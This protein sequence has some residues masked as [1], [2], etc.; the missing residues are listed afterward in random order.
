MSS[1]L[2][3]TNLTC[4]LAEADPLSN[5]GKLGMLFG[6]LAAGVGSFFLAKLLAERLHRPEMRS[7][8]TIGMGLTSI[9]VVITSLTGQL[10]TLWYLWLVIGIAILAYVAAQWLPRMIT[11]RQTG[12]RVTFALVVASLAALVIV[13]KDD[14]YQGMATLVILL[15]AVC[16]PYLFAKRLGEYLRASEYVWK[17]TCVLTSI[18]VAVVIVYPKPEGYD[19][20]GWP[21]K[22][23][24][25]LQGGVNLIYQF[26]PQSQDSAPE[27]EGNSVKPL[28]NKEIQKNLVNQL[29]R[30]I[31]P[32]GANDI[33][34]RPYGEQQVEV[35]VPNVNDDEIDLI[36]ELIT[37]AGKLEFR[38]LA[39]S[40]KH[41][42][43]ARLI[44][45]ER[46]K[47]QD[48]VLDFEAPTKELKR[49]GQWV[50][51]AREEAV[52]EGAVRAFRYNPLGDIMRDIDT[53]EP[54]TLTGFD[55]GAT[56]PEKAL[57]QYLADRG[58][59]DIEVL[60]YIGREDPPV[61]GSDLGPT[62]AG[63]ENLNP[64]IN[65]TLKRGPATTKFATLTRRNKPNR[66]ESEFSKLG[67]ILDGE[68]LS[69]PRIQSQINGRG[70]I[71][72]KFTQEQVDRL[73]EILRA[74][75]LSA[76]LQDTPISE[77][78]MGAELGQ[79]TINKGKW[80][81]QVS[82]L[83]VIVFVAIYYRFAG[84]VACLALVLNLL[85]VLATMILIDAAFTLPGMAGLI[86]TVGMSVDANVLI[87]ERI[88]EELARGARLRMA[89]RNGFARATT[90]I[91]DANL[92]T[93]ITAIVLYAIGTDQIRGFAVT[94]IL[95]I[96]M[97]MY[98]AIFCSRIVFELA[99][100]FR[101]FNSLKMMRIVGNTS[102]DFVGKRRLAGVLS[103]V[104]ISAGLFAVYSRGRD[105]FDIDFLGGTA[106]TL[107]LKEKITADEMDRICEK[108]FKSRRIKDEKLIKGSQEGAQVHYTI[109]SLDLPGSPKDT[110]WKLVTSVP[111]AEDLQQLVVEELGEHLMAYSL[112][113]GQLRAV[114]GSEGSS[115]DNEAD[116]APP[117]AARLASPDGPFFV[118]IDQQDEA[119]KK[120]DGAAAADETSKE[121]SEEQPEPK[122]PATDSVAQP[123][124]APSPTAAETASTEEATATP[125]PAVETVVKLTFGPE[126]SEE[127]SE[128]V[129]GLTLENKIRDAAEALDQPVTLKEGAISLQPLDKGYD[130]KWKIESELRYREWEVTLAQ[131]KQVSEKILQQL[132]SDL[133]GTPIFHSA[134][135]IGSKVAGDSQSLAI[136]A[137]LTSLLGIVG[138]IWIRF[139]RVVYGLA[140]VVALVHD[141]LITLGAIA[142]SF[143]VARSLNFLQV[144]EFSIS[145][146]IVAAFLTIIGYSLNDTIV[147]FDRIRE[148]RGKSPDLTGAMINDSINQTLSRTIL[149]SLTTFIVVAILYWFGGQGIHGFAFALVVGVV[150][151]TYSSIFIASP[152]LLWLSRLRQ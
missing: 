83:C 44:E 61:T 34:V 131:D 126:G 49:Q 10:L 140:A 2:D 74:G 132:K 116:P 63:Y 65:F 100:R 81:I 89:I 73:V 86:L 149:T 96:L 148:V 26:D 104:L 137:L 43:I 141:V 18:C 143:Y 39:N 51:V 57:A 102:I 88:R 121:T 108:A 103:I 114:A 64:M 142:L 40:H 76:V 118:S 31:N 78:K 85:L 70:Q 145:L 79:A 146:P 41:P 1:F 11:V 75:S 113:V 72:G 6:I 95:G 123:P 110:V 37:T 135:T 3:L 29:T 23:G 120:A 24:V 52:S 9:T 27:A 80:A 124:L 56:E 68:L 4:L 19:G 98:T 99:E 38:I 107:Q 84:I 101:R 77:N 45:D 14:N 15:L 136:K 97:S 128:R 25:D 151:G 115:T 92:T 33:V 106:L 30:R 152:T 60:V 36:K 66:D 28:T 133:T 82:L 5:W 22:Y 59:R 127:T 90:T 94:L 91:V 93:L 16:L 117:G 67:I 47:H 144:E 62:S 111:D 20:V 7:Q 112:T 8:W 55:M 139:Q 58:I 17:L 32:S 150:V 50:R 12:W 69:A 54:L 119:E 105:I 129:R 48:I 125:A 21:P 87:F 35:I 46:N 53:Q 71:T 42:G 130:P 134:N 138:Y 122:Q 13:P 109:N 147:V